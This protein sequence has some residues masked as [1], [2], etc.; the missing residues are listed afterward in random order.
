[1]SHTELEH[2][3]AESLGLPRLVF[4]LGDDTDGPA[5]MFRDPH[6]GARQEAFRA[7]LSDSGI[8]TATVTTP[9]GLEAALLHAL[10]ALAQPS[11]AAQGGPGGCGRCGRSRQDPRI[12]RPRGTAGGAGGGG[13]TRSARGGAGGHRDGRGGEDDPGDRVRPPAIGIGSMWRGGFPPRTRRWSPTACSLWRARSI[14][15]AR[16]GEPGGGARLLAAVARRDRWLVVFDNA[17]DPTALTPYLP[18]GPGRV[19]ITSRN[20]QWRRVA[21]RSG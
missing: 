2:Q 5:V 11:S 10:T 4:L 19:V 16:G 15:P 17:E 6:Y 9:D 3:A 12:H 8:T 18:Q 1:M 14:S 7:R 13:G 20:P 21:T